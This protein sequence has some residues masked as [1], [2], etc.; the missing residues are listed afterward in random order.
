MPSV[1]D[2]MRRHVLL[3]LLFTAL[4]IPSTVAAPQT[5]HS[6]QAASASTSQRPKWTEAN[7]KALLTKAQHGDAGAQFWL[8]TGYEQG[9][10]G[11]TD[12]QEALKCLRSAAKRGDPDAQNALGQMYGDGEG[13]P[14]NYAQAANWYRKAAE[15]VPNFGGADQGK[16]NLGLLYMNGLGVLKDYV[17]AYMWFSLANVE[18][19]R[20][21]AKAQM[22]PAQVLEAERMAAEWKTHHPE[23]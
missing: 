18:A 19:N 10:F 20:S 23:R 16:N 8:G 5:P 7:K 2:H 13:V 6:T 4:W 21:S 15:H 1:A 11:K 17:Q 22:T 3:R 9:W 14:Q 12:F